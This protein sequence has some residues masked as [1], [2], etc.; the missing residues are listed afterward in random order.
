MA[1]ISSL[2]A[3]LALLLPAERALSLPPLALADD[4]DARVSLQGPLLLLP[5][6]TRCTGTC[7]QT[8]VALHRANPAMPVVLLSFDPADTAQDLRDFRARFDLPAQWRLVRA[9]DT[10]AARAF[11]DQLDFHVMTAEGGFDHPNL[12]FLFSE[13][14]RWT[15]TFAGADFSQMKPPAFWL[16]PVA[17]IAAACAGLLLS[18]AAIVLVKSGRGA[19]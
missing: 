2:L 1:G 12:A 4:R 10:G 19:V 15:A 6:F 11:L 16:R 13:S 14:G 7:P 5:I 9:L 3:S 17:W 18:L 8:A